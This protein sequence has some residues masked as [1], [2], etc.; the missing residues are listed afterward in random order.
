MGLRWIF[1]HCTG[2]LVVMLHTVGNRENCFQSS[3]AVHLEDKVKVSGRGSI[4][5]YLGKA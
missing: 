1:L 2:S 5:R 3:L 4:V